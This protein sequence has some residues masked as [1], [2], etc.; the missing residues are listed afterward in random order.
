MNSIL[1]IQ[2]LGQNST[3][4]TETGLPSSLPHASRWAT[5]YLNSPQSDRAV[6]ISYG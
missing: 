6:T 1:G 5:S 4:K 2:T 3:N